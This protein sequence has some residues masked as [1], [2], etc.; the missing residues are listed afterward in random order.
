MNIQ[1]RQNQS[2]SLAKL[3]AIS[4]LYRR[5]KWTH[6]LGFFLVIL[7]GVFLTLALV[8]ED[9]WFNCVVT[10]VALGTWFLD[11]TYLKNLENVFKKEAATLQEEFD[12]FVLDIPW[13]EHKGIRHPPS[14]RINQ[15][16]RKWSESNTEL[17]DWYTLGGIPNDP[18][19]A[20][21]HCQKMNCWWDV[22]LRGVWKTLLKGVLWCSAIVS[23]VIAVLT[24]MTFGSAI[25]LT[26]ANLRILAWGI[27]EIR[28]QSAAIDHITRIHCYLSKIHAGKAP[29]S[30]CDIR[31][32]QGEIF[33]H[34]RSNPP[35]P[36]WLYRWKRDGQQSQA[37]GLRKREIVDRRQP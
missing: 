12:C 3:A 6:N 25:P 36:N 26:A 9:E 28:V 5:A 20:K 15:L 17:R 19:L 18:V 8:V 37:A 1:G 23:I 21:V 13:P 24:G 35:V 29:I 7:V 22:E 4:V 32:L 16:E 30:L 34:R 14:D 11:Q 33:E 31:L 2:E 27:G 10:L